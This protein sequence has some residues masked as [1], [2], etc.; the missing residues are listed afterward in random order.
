[1]RSG[2]AFGARLLLV[3]I[4]LAM[5]ALPASGGSA[6][7]ARDIVTRGRLEAGIGAGYW[8]G[9]DLVEGT[10]GG[11]RAAAF[12]LPRFGIV[13]TDPFE[14]GRLTGNLQ[15]IAEP[16]FARFTRPFSAEAAGGA[17]I[18]K[19]NLLSFGRWMPFWEVGAG[20]L[21]TNLAPRIPEQ[22]IPFNFVLETGPGVQYF[23]TTTVSVTA[24]VR[25]H[26]ISN[27]GIGDRNR[28]LN[29]VLPYA[30]FSVFFG[31]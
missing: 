2:T 16:F 7:D 15:L 30:G 29:G 31:R 19:Y 5:P 28:G 9:V 17:L 23:I 11:D 6:P 20:L 8:Q 25:F 10:P 1:M 13:L 21:W 4:L 24:G 27:A 14:A 26:H 18:L 22:S 3:G 12:L